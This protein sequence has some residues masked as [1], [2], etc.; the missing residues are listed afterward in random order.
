MKLG[1]LISVAREVKGWTLRDLEASIGISNALLSQVETGKIKNPG[2]GNVVRIAD[3]LGI[4]AER[5]FAAVRDPL[6]PV[7][8]ECYGSGQ[9]TT[10]TATCITCGG[11]G[12]RP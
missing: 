11:S 9:V 6:V 7:C 10:D 2:I 5:V 12:K 4:S 1:E 3:A 8:P